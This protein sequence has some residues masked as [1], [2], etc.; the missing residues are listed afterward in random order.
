MSSAPRIVHSAGRASAR[1][2]RRMV[3][4]DTPHSSA[5]RTADTTA[6]EWEEFSETEQSAILEAQAWAD[7]Q[8]DETPSEGWEMYRPKSPAKPK[9]AKK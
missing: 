7:G 4:S 1:S 5:A 2:H 6:D 8:S 9:Q 3:R